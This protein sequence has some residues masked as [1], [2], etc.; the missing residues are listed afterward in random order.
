MR[1]HLDADRREYRVVDTRQ[2][3]ADQDANPDPEPCASTRML[4]TF[5]RSPRKTVARV[6]GWPA[7]PGTNSERHQNSNRDT[8]VSSEERE[9]LRSPD[10]RWDARPY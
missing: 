2:N 7:N 6:H 8:P 10:T 5:A 1:T 4:S 9:A 3:Y